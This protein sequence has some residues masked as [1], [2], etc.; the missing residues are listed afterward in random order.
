MAGP[1]VTASGMEYIEVEVLADCVDSLLKLGFCELSTEG[2][3]EAV[4]TLAG[5]IVDNDRALLLKVGIGW[6]CDDGSSVVE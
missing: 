6:C 5:T 1:T 3:P 2:D 4:R